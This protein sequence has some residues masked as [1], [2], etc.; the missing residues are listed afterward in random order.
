V[1][2]PTIYEPQTYHFFERLARQPDE[3]A[4]ELP[5]VLIGAHNQVYSPFDSTGAPKAEALLGSYSYQDGSADAFNPQ[6]QGE[7][8]S[9]FPV[10][11]L[12]KG[13]VLQD[14]DVWTEFGV[15]ASRQ[16]VKLRKASGETR[17]INHTAGT[18]TLKP[19]ST[20]KDGF[21]FTL[22]DATVNFKR[23]LSK[24]TVVYPSNNAEYSAG[25]W[26]VIRLTEGVGGPFLVKA[27][28]SD[29]D[30]YSLDLEALHYVPI[31]ADKTIKYEL[32][33]NP[34]EFS[35]VTG[36]QAAKVE[37]ASLD[38]QSAFRHLRLVKPGIKTVT[39]GNG[40]CGVLELTFAA[41]ASLFHADTFTLV[42]SAGA[43]VV[44]T[45]DI[46]GLD[47]AGGTNEIDIATGASLATVVAAAAN[48]INAEGSFKAVLN[49]KNP[50]QVRVSQIANGVAG[51]K[52]VTRTG[53]F[54]FFANAPD[55]PADVG[56]DE[57]AQ[58]YGGSA[59]VGTSITFKNVTDKPVRIKLNAPVPSSEVSTAHPGWQVNGNNEYEAIGGFTLPDSAQN[60]VWDL[61]ALLTSDSDNPYAYVEPSSLDTWTDV[62]NVSPNPSVSKSQRL[63]AAADLSAVDFGEGANGE[64]L[65][66]AATVKSY[67][68]YDRLV[69]AFQ[70]DDDFKVTLAST[71]R[72]SVAASAAAIVSEKVAT[73]LS[74]PID[75]GTVPVGR[76]ASS[77]GSPLFQQAL[78][79]VN[80]ELHTFYQS[81]LAGL[82]YDH[83]PTDI[84][85][86]V[87]HPSEQSHYA[88]ND[89][90]WLAL[91]DLAAIGIDAGLANDLQEIFYDNAGSITG[92]NNYVGTPADPSHIITAEYR[93]KGTAGNDLSFG[94]LWNSNGGAVALGVVTSN[95]ELDVT[96]PSDGKLTAETLNDVATALDEK[97]GDG[98]YKYPVKISKVVDYATGVEVAAGEDY[99]GWNA[100]KVDPF[101]VQE[102]SA[103]TTIAGEKRKSRL[104]TGE[105]AN[106][107]YGADKG[108]VIRIDDTL[109]GK[110]SVG[111]IKL[112]AEYVALRTDTS[113][114]ATISEHGR[115]ADIVRVRKQDLETVLGDLTA[116]NPLGLAASQYFA[117]SQ[118]ATCYILGVDEVSTDDPHGTQA[119]VQRA[120]DFGKSRKGYHH[121]IFNDGKW[122][123]STV[124]AFCQGLGGTET[125]RLKAS[126]YVYT[127][128]KIPSVGP[129]I[130][131]A[132]G[133]EIQEVI[134]VGDDTR[135]TTN[136]D[137]VAAGIQAD[138]VLVS[139][140]FPGLG[141]TT[142]ADGR[143]GYS[144]VSVDN[145][146]P[147]QLVLTGT[148]SA[149]IY[150]DEGETEPFEVWRPGSS[151][152]SDNGAFD[153]ETAKDALIEYHTQDGYFD[154]RHQKHGGV[155]NYHDMVNGGL[156]S[157]DGIFLL[158]QY[159]GI[160]GRSKDHLP[161]SHA[162]YASTVENLEGTNSLF[163]SEQLAQMRGA[164]LTFPVQRLAPKGQV[165]VSRDVS[166]DTSTRTLRRRGS[167]VTEDIL[168]LRIDRRIKP[169]LAQA[170][171]TTQF[172]DQIAA[173]MDSILQWFRDAE[174]FKSLTLESMDIIDDAART[175]YGI[176]D[177]GLLIS[178]RYEHLEEAGAMMFRHLVEPD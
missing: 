18:A 152:F 145:A 109:R 160:I 149:V 82:G 35:F 132:Q 159:M 131:K 41:E 158:G 71:D 4:V 157:L 116:K 48:A 136:L 12:E 62:T 106:T 52:A 85:R 118:G 68:L 93:T 30:P 103:Y 129:D 167:I 21:S 9:E 54:N 14:I 31:F 6:G 32:I 7:E 142:L 164:G 133:D 127:P 40:H 16:L 28:P 60:S 76:P 168:R 176:D 20:N 26:A 96:L 175:K 150:T 70:A 111:S 1:T 162:A 119:A 126:V 141:D 169:R 173:D 153:S 50:A 46:D 37:F 100:V 39:T 58:F 99:A 64:I 73:T 130:R 55:D 59:S 87:V 135:V 36:T 117:T 148:V 122:L 154:K 27:A 51:N 88:D 102:I 81:E 105:E 17:A 108:A 104:Y 2:T 123:E 78:D 75:E 29:S 156:T 125:A 74:L 121:A 143:K 13:A 23:V 79:A 146:N 57:K 128:F 22:Q 63:G 38:R 89:T 170:L 67:P 44:F 166:G 53:T 80:T 3:G 165:I 137:V 112:Y 66:P 19:D 90:D 94:F 86:L 15:G 147:T 151:L 115:L 91:P 161:T 47:P 49:P 101:S 138:D 24:H 155:N 120:L 98:T 178:I 83:A 65:I 61:N 140:A 113:A 56:N 10:P 33:I 110:G 84:L 97:N 144:V 34:R 72:G 43:S 174:L 95:G 42:D 8:W 77:S 134:A 114:I 69:G 25:G 139:L 124:G 5:V 177:T 171:L 163:D 45:I 107:R 172:L 11:K 92:V